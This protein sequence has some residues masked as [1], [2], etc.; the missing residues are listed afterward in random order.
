MASHPD[1]SEIWMSL[2]QQYIEVIWLVSSERVNPP[3]TTHLLTLAW[4]T[5]YK[6]RSLLWTVALWVKLTTV[7]AGRM[8]IIIFSFLYKEP[9]VNP[10]V[11]VT[12]VFNKLILHNWKCNSSEH[13]QKI[14]KT[15]RFQFTHDDYKF[16]N[17][18]KC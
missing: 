17:S 8:M 10:H 15:F 11:G 18:L 12:F 2:L 13:T 7:S 4:P 14:I 16:R 9:Y 6:H 1:L 3:S 5:F